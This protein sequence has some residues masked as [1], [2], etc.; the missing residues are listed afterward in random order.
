[1]ENSEVF[2]MTCK[3]L[4]AKMC[5]RLQVRIQSWSYDVWIE[6]LEPLTIRD[7]VLVL[8]APSALNINVIQDKY[9]DEFRAVLKELD[10][11]VTEVE[12]RPND[13][14]LAMLTQANVS[15]ANQKTVEEQPSFTFNP[16]FTFDS[17][18]VGESNKFLYAVANR[19]A[20]EPGM[21]G[22]NPLFIY[23]G[24]GLGKTHIMHAIG[25]ELLA[26]QPNLKV[27][28]STSEKFTNELIESIRMSKERPSYNHDFR[29]KY[30]S[31]DVLMIDDIQFIEGKQGTQEEFFHTFNDLIDKNKQIIITSDRQPREIPT[32]EDRLR[33]RF[34]MGM[35]ADVQHPDLE[36]KI[37]I[38]QKKAEQERYLV[39]ND[40]LTMIAQRV[41]S[42]VREMQGL[43]SKVAFYGQLLNQP[44]TM[45]L[46][47]EA[48]KDHIDN[49]QEALS[50][51][52]II[53]VVCKY[54]NISKDDIKGKKKTKE[55][56]VPRQIC[57]YLIYD[58]LGL[59]L[60][61]IGQQFGGRD[62]TTVIHARDKIAEGQ[63]TDS[64]LAMQIK[65]LRNMI[66]GQ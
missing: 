60:A 32:L 18:V 53:D 63:K 6:K 35:I 16:K 11:F 64:R 50:A 23:G 25:N 22:L 47:M 44:V 7:N 62:H 51:D 57:I 54:F 36:T 21:A 28:Y 43:L 10:T 2:Y 48:I 46:A 1:M 19:V 40:V 14:D 42:N 61:S 56:V 49:R 8:V 30:R 34:E 31:A 13:P 59:P 41:E 33:T 52:Y 24:V 15:T 45:E 55:I 29:E 26:K 20:K 27:I 5:E 66:N 39:P 65:D 58:I 38:L 12:F 37:A 3:E 9:L 4:W 17:F